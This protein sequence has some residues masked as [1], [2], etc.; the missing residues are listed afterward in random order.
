[1]SHCWDLNAVC[2]S[3]K[4][5]P[6]SSAREM[7]RNHLGLFLQIQRP[8]DSDLV[9]LEWGLAWRSRSSIADY[10]AFS[11]WR[12]IAIE[13]DLLYWTVPITHFRK[14]A[15]FSALYTSVITVKWSCYQHGKDSLLITNSFNFK[16]VLIVGTMPEIVPS[17]Y[18]QI[19]PVLMTQPQTEALFITVTS[20]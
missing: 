6:C 12:T 5:R 14:C 11:L 18:W 13:R 17:P 10:S 20:K 15:F 3:P 8:E 9:H 16:R 7:H 4:D 19:L 1:M 2:A